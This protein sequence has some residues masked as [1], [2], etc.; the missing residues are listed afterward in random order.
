MSFRKL[1]INKVKKAIEGSFGNKSVIAKRC[2]CSWV[3]VWDFFNKHPDLE[4]QLIK[5]RDNIVYIAEQKLL[6]IIT[7]GE[8]KDK[9][10]MDAVLKVLNSKIAID[11]GWNETHEIINKNL[12][13]NVDIDS[14]KN[15]NEIWVEIENE[16]SIRQR[17]TETSTD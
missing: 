1:T 12:N 4:K 3:A 11:K 13:V 10:T 9:T 8:I 17:N 14:P 16:K 7:K 2:D 6:Q 5:E 15:M